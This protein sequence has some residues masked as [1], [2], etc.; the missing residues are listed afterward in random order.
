MSTSVEANSA[1]AGQRGE[2]KA[3]GIKLKASLAPMTALEITSFDP[4]DFERELSAKVAQ[5]PGFF[6]NLPVVIGLE[7]YTAPLSTF[8][9]F[10]TFAMHT[11]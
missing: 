7:K 10:S 1:Q 4:E 2:T 11:R 9:N 5:A 3:P 6:E 8:S